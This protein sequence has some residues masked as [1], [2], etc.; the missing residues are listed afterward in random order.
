M[1]R[2]VYRKSVEEFARLQGEMIGNV[3]RTK[4]RWIPMWI[5]M[6]GLRIFVKVR[7]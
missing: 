7:H 2:K 1:K 3:L 6:L 5:W 4:P